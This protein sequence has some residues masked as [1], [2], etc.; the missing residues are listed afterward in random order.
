MT[1]AKGTETTGFWQA[2]YSNSFRGRERS[3]SVVSLRQMRQ[4]S[5]EE[6]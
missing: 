3:E 1:P 2:M 6:M 4:T 5:M